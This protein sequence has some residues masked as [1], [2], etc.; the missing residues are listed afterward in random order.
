ML[1]GATKTAREKILALVL[2]NRANHKQYAKVRNHLAN[3]FTQGID[4]YLKTI[5]SSVC[6]LDNYKPLRHVQTFTGH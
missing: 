2:L 6:L 4:G 1:D 5:E 3:Q